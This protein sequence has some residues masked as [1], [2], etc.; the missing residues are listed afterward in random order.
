MTDIRN[1]IQNMAAEE[2]AF[3]RTRFVA[4]CVTGGRV[5]ARVAGLVQTFTPRPADF[6][7]WGVFE[8]QGRF[9]RRVEEADLMQVDAYLK[10]FP[11]LRV[12]LARQLQGQ[13]WLAF[14]ASEAD[15][16]QRFGDA[17]PVVV[18][19]VTEGTP[20]EQATV[21]GGVGAFWF[22]AIDRR[23]DPLPAEAMRDALRAITEPEALAF[24]GITPEMRTV[25]DLVAQQ[26]AAFQEARR[27]REDERR[28]RAEAA[29]LRD[30]RRRGRMP[31]YAA[32]TAAHRDVYGYAGAQPA[33]P[34]A[35]GDTE[36]LREALRVGGGELRQAS[37]RGEYWLVE[38]TTRT[39][40]RQT[41]AIAK[42]D[43]TVISSGICL[44]GRDR[45]FDLQS[46]VGVIER[47][48]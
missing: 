36:R 39:G 15:M 19:L 38:W 8:P 32:D 5:R 31:H 13:T 10:L 33:A 34:A 6:E 1:L 45:N 27:R 48:S 2:A 30:T 20:F 11:T 40:H 42:G 23:A 37:D 14:P 35:Q 16:A 4:P 43:L 29:Y 24:P 3:A 46:L 44:S 26:D 47:R 12:R 41:S 21:C 17:R 9:A 25:Y 28:R 22:E 18:H 7:G